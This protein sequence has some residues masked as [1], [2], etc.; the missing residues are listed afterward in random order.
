MSHRDSLKGCLRH[1]AAL[2]KQ[3]PYDLLSIVHNREGKYYTLLT[4]DELVAYQ[5][6][7]IAQRVR[8][9]CTLS[10]KELRAFTH[11]D[12]LPLNLGGDHADH[13]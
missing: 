8:L 1:M 4:E 10:Q 3:Q 9:V 2:F 7:H 12:Q 11:S 6:R 13:A 5:Q